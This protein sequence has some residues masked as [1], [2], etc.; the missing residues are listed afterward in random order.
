[1]GI[2]A[3]AVLVLGLLWVCTGCVNLDG[4]RFERRPLEETI[5]R[6]S[7]GPKLLLLDIQGPITDQDEAGFLSRDEGSVPRVAEQLAHAAAKE[8]KGVLL[9]IDTPGGTASASEVIYRQLL[10]F[11]AERGLPIVAH[12][13]GTATSGGYYVAMA[14][15]EIRA[16][17]TSIT[18]SIGVIAGG[19]NVAGLMDRFGVADQTIK[20][21]AF[22][23]TGSPFRAMREDERAHMQSIVDDLYAR[24]VEVVGKGRP[25]LDAERIGTLADGRIYSAPQALE[26][27]LIDGIGS[28]EESIDRLETLAGIGQSRVVSLHRPGEYRNNLFTRAPTSP[29]G[30]LPT[31]AGEGGPALGGARSLLRSL[32][33]PGFHYLWLPGLDTRAN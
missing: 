21:G 18:G 20:S 14:A 2:R 25:K 17:P 1:M 28:L 15:D 10:A 4:L 3:G 19:L 9:R 33:G 32:P 7:S 22:K 27:G 12:F 16:Y 23:D 11:K 31:G 13:M 6:G 8:M 24:F 26:N 29:P 5:V 30:V